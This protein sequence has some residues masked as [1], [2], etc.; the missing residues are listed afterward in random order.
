MSFAD[1]IKRRLDELEAAGTLRIPRE[2]HGPQGPSLLL[3]GRRVLVFCSNNYL[4]LASDPRILQALGAA[5]ESTGAGSGASRHVSGTSTIHRAAEQRLAAFV[6]LPASLLF[7][8]GYAANLGAIQALVGP[9]DVVFSDALNH[10]SLIDGCRLSRAE[11]YV[12]RHLD[13]GHL[14]ALL[15][16]HC[17][18]DRAA[19]VVTE[20]YFSMDGD[21]G[22]LGAIEVLARK[23]GAGFMVDEAHALGVLGPSGFGLCAEQGAQPD[24][25][26]GTLGKAFGLAGAFVAGQPDTVRLVENRARSFVFS[27]AIPPAI[28]AAAITAT[29]IIEAANAERQRVTDLADRLRSGL[30]ELGFRVTDGRGPI[31]PVHVGPP[32]ATMQ[33]SQALLEQGVFVHGIRP[34]TVPSGTSRLR[35]TVMA[36]HS[37]DDVCAALDAFRAVR[38]MYHTIYNDT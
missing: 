19:L 4:G 16:R 3:D 18:T 29:D 5:L 6:D 26:V 35:V 11:V 1:H 21:I 32:E 38:G 30:R 2:L 25:L 8:S 27:T 14:G 10:A 12:Y 22:A 17:S 37:D 15:E 33:L 36:T 7:A 34:P 24:I 20:S 13:A 31:I 9:G 23:H 28:A